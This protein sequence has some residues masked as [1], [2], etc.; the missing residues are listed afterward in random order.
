MVFAATLANKITFK[1]KQAAQINL[2]YAVRYIHQ[3]TDGQ[4]RLFVLGNF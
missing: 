3:K 4:H 1:F 2:K